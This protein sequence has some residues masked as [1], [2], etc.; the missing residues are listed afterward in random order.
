MDWRTKETRLNDGNREVTIL[1]D[2]RRERIKEKGIAKIRCISYC[3]L[4]QGKRSWTYQGTRNERER[5]AL[6]A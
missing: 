4:N 5:N 3:W 6:D 2:L 1:K